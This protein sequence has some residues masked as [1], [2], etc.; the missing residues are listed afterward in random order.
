MKLVSLILA[1][2]KGTRMNSN[3]PKVVHKVNGIPMVKKIMNILDELKVEK[4]ILILGHKKEVVL[5]NAGEENTYVV[6]EEVSM[7]KNS[8]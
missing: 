1:A 6:Q 8:E 7:V 5:K 4:N 2:G 3:L